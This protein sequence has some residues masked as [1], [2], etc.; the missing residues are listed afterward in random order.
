[1]SLILDNT[2]LPAAL[3]ANAAFLAT[4]RALMLSST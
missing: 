2:M 1:M 3:A 4:P